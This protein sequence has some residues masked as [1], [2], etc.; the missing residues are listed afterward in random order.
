MNQT[1]PRRVESAR[2]ALVTY[3]HDHALSSGDRLPAYAQL[4]E[5][6]GFGSQTIAAA[7]T[8][9]CKLGV[10]E[11]RDKVGIFVADPEGGHLT[12]RT[13]AVAVRS[14]AGSAY[15]AT[16]AGFIQKQLTGRN[17][18]CLTFYQ[19]SDPADSPEP[20]LAE[21]PGL[22]QVIS[23]K[24]CDGVITLCPLAATS[25]KRLRSL[26]VPCC[27]IGD[28]D[29]GPRGLSVL[30]GV[31]DFFASAIRA[32]KE[33]G[34][35]KIIQLCATEEQRHL[36][37]KIGLPALVGASYDGG[38]DLAGKLLALPEEERPDGIV[39]DDDTIVSGLLCGLV[40]RQLPLVE[41]LPTVAGIIHR[42]LKE[43]YPSGKLV[44]FRQDIEQYATLAVDLLLDVLR[45]GDRRDRQICYKFELV[46]P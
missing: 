10:L 27:F 30:I 5:E 16:L 19:L 11:V 18:R 15:A 2:N 37:Q 44:L 43:R 6:F 41:Y 24:R 20:E 7:V 33:A 39:S 42:E 40:A 21:F 17:C 25:R 22:E 45:T 26:D 38:D 4:R 34:C 1:L 12:G 36:R 3:I 9:L 28:S 23:E 35:R 46:E 31:E 29:A 32:L 14:L 8:S 13:I